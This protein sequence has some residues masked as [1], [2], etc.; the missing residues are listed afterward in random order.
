MEVVTLALEL[1]RCV[2][3]V[4]HDPGDGL[5]DIL[6]PLGHL[7]VAH[8]VDLLDEVV[9]FLPERHLGCVMLSLRGDV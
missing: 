5:L 6:H 1:C 9:I 4:S 3:F 2:D 7:G 8:L